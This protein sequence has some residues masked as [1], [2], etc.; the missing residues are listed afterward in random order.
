MATSH[1]CNG[2]WRDG[3]LAECDKHTL[4]AK[5][6]PNVYRGVG[7]PGGRSSKP[8]KSSSKGSGGSSDG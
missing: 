8:P 1:Y 6:Q 2:K 5:R 7:D 4:L 3:T